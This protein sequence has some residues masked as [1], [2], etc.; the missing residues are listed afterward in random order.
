MAG[1]SGES[2]WEAELRVLRQEIEELRREQREMANSLQQLVTTF[3]SL[4]THLG[5]AAEP[6]A[7]KKKA[8]R[9]LP[10]FA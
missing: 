4:A 9:D 8:D 10:G 2:H 5:I 7:G 3:K 6:Y 1:S